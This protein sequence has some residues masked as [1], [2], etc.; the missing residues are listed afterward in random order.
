MSLCPLSTD[1]GRRNGAEQ[2]Q[3][4]KGRAAGFVSAE[5][6]ATPSGRLASSCVTCPSSEGPSLQRGRS[7]PGDKPAGLQN[8]R[9][10]RKLICR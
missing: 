2:G 6:Q 9:G 4:R 1:P 5:G 10:D 3:A 8:C 7:G